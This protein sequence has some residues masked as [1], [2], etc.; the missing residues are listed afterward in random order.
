MRHFFS[1]RVRAVLL[2]ALLL[3]VGLVVLGTLTDLSLPEMVVKGVLTPLRTAASKLTDQAEQ[4]YNYMFR[5]E[6]LAAENAALREQIAQMEEDSRKA[7]SVAREN[8]RLKALLGWLE[9]NE[10]YQVLS[11]Y[12]IAWNSNDWSSTLTVDRGTNHGIE[13]G[14]CAVTA[15]GAMVGLV[16]ETGTNYSVIKTVL[17]S[18]LEVSA[19]ISASGYNGMVHGSYIAGQEGLLRMEYLPTSAVIRNQDQVVTTGSTV[20]PRGLLIGRVVDAGYDDSGIAKFA[21]VEPGVDVSTLE[22]VFILTSFEVD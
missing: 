3:A 7:D 14:M 6:A 17:D 13:V 1:P 18:S 21:L 16:V 12:I 22:Q 20:Y 4:I 9:H 10:D 5:Y 11:T 19:T 15:D 2:I 8:D